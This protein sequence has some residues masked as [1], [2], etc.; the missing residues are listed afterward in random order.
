MDNTRGLWRGIDEYD[1][2]ERANGEWVEGSLIITKYPNG[3]TDYAIKSLGYLKSEPTPVAPETLGRCTG[4]RDNRQK[5]IFEGDVIHIWGG[6]HEFGF[7]E[8]EENR[9]VEDIT[10]GIC[11][12]IRNSDNMEIIGNIFDNPKLA[13]NIRD[14]KPNELPFDY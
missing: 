6:I 1:F 9:I 13:K 14:N 10:D 4:L 5:L 12:L 8:F 11:N 2:R 3:N 7:W